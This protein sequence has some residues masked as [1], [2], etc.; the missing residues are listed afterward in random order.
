MAPLLETLSTLSTPF[1][2][3]CCAIHLCLFLALWWAYRRDLR[4]IAGTLDAFTRDLKPRSVLEPTAHLADQIDAFLADVNEVLEN[5]NRTAD[6]ASLLE[7]MQILDEK[8]SYLQSMGFDT[9]YNLCR[10]MIE[11]YP[12]MGILGTILAIG[13]VLQGGPDSEPTVGLLVTRFGEAIWST[14]AGLVAA[15][16]LMFINSMLETPFTRLSESRLNVRDTVLRAKRVLSLP[17]GAGGTP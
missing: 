7:R 3:V 8:R 12:L 4:V 17:D 10:N 5:P 13:V 16:G 14:F 11:S 15:V 2:A 6:R 9:S 1:I